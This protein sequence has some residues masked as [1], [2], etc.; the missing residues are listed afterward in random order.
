MLPKEGFSSFNEKLMFRMFCIKLQENISLINW[1]V[2][3][4][5][6]PVLRLKIN[7]N[8]F[9]KN[10]FVS[11]CLGQ[12]G[13]KMNFLGYYQKSI[14]TF[15][16]F[17]DFTAAWKFKLT[18]MIFLKKLCFRVFW[19]KLAKNGPQMRF[20]KFCAKSVHITLLTFFHE[21]TAAALRN[22]FKV[23]ID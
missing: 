5:K 10:D 20:F 3:F 15:Q 17:N 1:S 16:F 21:V 8:N 19:P 2:L 11:M 18:I 6:N 22:F 4:R 23:K 9:F 14:R 7:G 13:P 12:N